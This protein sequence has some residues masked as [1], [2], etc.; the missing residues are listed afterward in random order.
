MGLSGYWQHLHLIKRVLSSCGNGLDWKID[1][2][3]VEGTRL[4]TPLLGIVHDSWRSEGVLSRHE[5]SGM[6]SRNE[7]SGGHIIRSTLVFGEGLIV[8]LIEL[9]L[10]IF[11]VQLIVKVHMIFA[12]IVFFDP[13]LSQDLLDESCLF[14]NVLL[15]LLSDVWY[16]LLDILGNLLTFLQFCRVEFC[17]CFC[18][19]IFEWQKQGLPVVNIHIQQLLSLLLDLCF[20]SAYIFPAQL[21]FFLFVLG[22]SVFLDGFIFYLQL[23]GLAVVDPRVVHDSY[24]IELYELNELNRVI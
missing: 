8:K 24:Y 18:A 17:F 2:V 20:L 1:E 16:S 13:S 10:V 12:F 23:L 4:S 21:L 22:Y 11:G 3:L 5:L 19:K 14:I 15:L 7:W 9:L 6:L